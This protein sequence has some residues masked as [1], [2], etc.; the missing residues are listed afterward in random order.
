MSEQE[1]ENKEQIFCKLLSIE[2]A[3]SFGDSPYTTLIFMINGKIEQHSLSDG[4]L[5]SL[6]KAAEDNCFK[7]C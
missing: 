3:G 5:F 4:K 2:N 6:I 7:P 1:I